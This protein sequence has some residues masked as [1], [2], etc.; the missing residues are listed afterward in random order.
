MEPSQYEFRDYSAQSDSIYYYVVALYGSIESA[1][2]NTVEVIIEPV[3]NADEMV[4][5]LLNTI[6]IGPNPFRDMAVIQYQLEKQ[7]EVELKIYNLKGQLI[8]TLP[9]GVQNKGNQVLAWDGSDDRMQAVASGLYFIRMLADGK[10]ITTRK[11]LK[12]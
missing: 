10:I 4:L 11:I 5:P 7:S 3:A 1:P 12:I 6:S 2:S 9:Q 8:R